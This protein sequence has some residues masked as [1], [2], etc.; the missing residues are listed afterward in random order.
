MFGTMR[1]WKP[2][3]GRSSRLRPLAVGDPSGAKRRLIDTLWRR[4]AALSSPADGCPPGEARERRSGEIPV[5]AVACVPSKGKPRGASSVRRAKHVS[6]RQGLRE[7][8][9]P[10]NRGLRGRPRGFGCVVAPVGGT[11]GGSTRVVTPVYL[12]GGERSEG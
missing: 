12:P 11:V 9:K 7:G 6:G 2:S 5:E 1:V 3:K 4:P 8:S 10:R